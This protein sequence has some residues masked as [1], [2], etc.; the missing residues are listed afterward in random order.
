MEG[1]ATDPPPTYTT[2]A[3]CFTAGCNEHVILFHH[4]D[5]RPG[6]YSCITHRIPSARQTINL[7]HVKCD[8]KK[9]NNR[10]LYRIQLEATMSIPV[11][12]WLCDS[13][14]QIQGGTFE[15]RQVIAINKPVP[16]LSS[17]T[18]LKPPEMLDS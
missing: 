9:C 7:V 12:A 5:K 11:Y 16:L 6:V 14:V 13:C 3:P 15:G 18:V 1:P 10:A 2:G 8:A 17:T 4:L